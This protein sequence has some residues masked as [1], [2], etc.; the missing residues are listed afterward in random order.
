MSQPDEPPV[1][2][3]QPMEVVAVPEDEPTEVIEEADP[4]PPLIG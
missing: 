3:Q 2:P 4:G 1:P